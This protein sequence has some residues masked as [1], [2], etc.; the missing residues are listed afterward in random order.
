MRLCSCLQGCT[1]EPFIPYVGPFPSTS[2]HFLSTL[3]R[4]SGT[5]KRQRHVTGGRRAAR[6]VLYILT[7]AGIRWNPVL[8]TFYQRLRAAGKPP[9]VAIVACMRKLLTILN[10][11]VRDC[12]K[13]C[14]EPAG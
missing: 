11:M 3:N 10:A 9:K 1:P 14:P 6:E 8:R 7:I 4:D 13:W 12:R 2:D 5:Q